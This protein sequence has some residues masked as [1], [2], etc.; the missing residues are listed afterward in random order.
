VKMDKQQM[1]KRIEELTKEIK[2]VHTPRLQQA[3]QMINNEQIQVIAKKGII[4]ELTNQVSKEG[5]IK[6][7]VKTK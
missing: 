2:E 3:Q 7:K 1:K 4:E 6:K 5:D